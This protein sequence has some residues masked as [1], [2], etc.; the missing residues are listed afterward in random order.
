MQ[1]QKIKANLEIGIIQD[2]THKKG[3]SIFELANWLEFGTDRAPGWHYNNLAKE[4]AGKYVS[5]KILDMA[6]LYLKE[7]EIGGYVTALGYTLVRD[8]IK[9]IEDIKIPHNSPA[10][11][12][13]KGFDDPLIETGEFKTKPRARKDGGGIYG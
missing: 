5:K 11:I 1:S 2:G 13:K 3:V 6:N 7:G 4:K 12:A 9:N 8:Y 10:T